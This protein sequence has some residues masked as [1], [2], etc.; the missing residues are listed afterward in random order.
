MALSTSTDIAGMQAGQATIDNAVGTFQGIYSSMTDQMSTLAA[1][2]MGETSTTFGQSFSRF[3]EDV[4]TC[5]NSLQNVS[6]TIGVN[7][8]VYNTTNNTSQDTATALGNQ[9]PTALGLPALGA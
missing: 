8:G 3:L 5:I 9:V 2:W 1:N 6:S 7:S 4:M